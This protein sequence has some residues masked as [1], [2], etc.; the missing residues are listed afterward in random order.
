MRQQKLV[1]TLF[2]LSILL[3][4]VHAM[5]MEA[6]WYVMYPGF[7]VFVH[8]LGGVIIAAFAL[9]IY[10]VVYPPV[11]DAV[12]SAY[13]LAYIVTATVVVGIGWEIVEQQLRLTYDAGYSI[14]TAKDVMVDLAGALVFAVVLWWRSAYKSTTL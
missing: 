8:L 3:T 9:Y 13:L 10:N 11:D 4:L 7:D 2:A 5:A 6:H 12:P 14:A 1:G